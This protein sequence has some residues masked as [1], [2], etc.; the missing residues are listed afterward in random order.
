[1]KPTTDAVERAHAVLERAL[2]YMGWLDDFSDVSPMLACSNDANEGRARFFRYTIDQVFEPPSLEEVYAALDTVWRLARAN[3]DR[4][5]ASLLAGPPESR[6]D[7]RT[8]LVDSIAYLD[9]IPRPSWMVRSAP[10]DAHPTAV[11]PR[12]RPLVRLVRPAHR[13]RPT[14]RARAARRRARAASLVR[15]TAGPPADAPPEPP[16]EGPAPRASRKGGAR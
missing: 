2:A 11:A 9:G 13:A 3:R 5:A 15:S 4:R 16:R 10:L 7:L 8:W 1:L 14:W 12:G 6:D